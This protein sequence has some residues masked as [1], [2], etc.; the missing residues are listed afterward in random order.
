MTLHITPDRITSDR[1]PECADRLPGGDWQLSWLPGRALT[2]E[3]A[4][5]G[6]ELDELLSHR[7]GVHDRLTHA[8]IH[9]HA[10]TLGMLWEQA[11]II[12]FKRM[13]E[14]DFAITPAPPRRDPP[15]NRPRSAP[16]L[17]GHLSAGPAYYG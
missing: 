2:A 11:A 3:Q 8:R 10:D 15:P 12:L 5:A 13:V 6:M 7:D 1:T 4:R 14:R 17:G 9:T 16:R